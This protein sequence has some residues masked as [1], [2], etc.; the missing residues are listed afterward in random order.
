M[1]QAGTLHTWEATALLLLPNTSQP[2][3]AL[4]NGDGQLTNA[5]FNSHPSWPL[6]AVRAGSPPPRQGTRRVTWLSGICAVP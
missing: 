3:T 6:A 4:E 5:A 2:H 1:L